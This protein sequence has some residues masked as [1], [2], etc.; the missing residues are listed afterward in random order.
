MKKI[1]VVNI[2]GMTATPLPQSGQHRRNDRDI[3]IH[4]VVN[5]MGMKSP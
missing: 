2:A 1:M 4:R 5:I 3:D